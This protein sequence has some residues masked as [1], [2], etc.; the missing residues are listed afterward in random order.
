M[1]PWGSAAR[2]KLG[3]ELDQKKIWRNSRKG[4]LC[5]KNWAANFSVQVL[6]EF[7]GRRPTDRRR[8]LD[9]PMFGRCSV[10]VRSMLGR[11][12]VDAQSMFGRCSFDLG[13]SWPHVWATATSRTQLGRHSVDARSM[14]GQHSVDARSML[15]RPSVDAPSLKAQRRKP[16]YLW[17]KDFA[18]QVQSRLEPS[19]TKI[20]TE[21]LVDQF[22]THD[23]AK[24]WRSS[25]PDFPTQHPLTETWTKKYEKIGSP[26]FWAQPSFTGTV[27]KFWSSWTAVF[28][29]QLSLTE[30]WT[31]KCEKIGSPVFWAQPSFTGTV[32]N[33]L[34]Q[35]NRSFLHA[36]L[37]HPNLDEKI[38]KNWQPSFLSTTFL[39][40]N[41]CKI[42]GPV[43][44]RF[45]H[46]ALPHRNLDGKIGS[47]VS[48]A[49]FSHQ[50]LA[51]KI[52]GPTQ[53]Q[54]FLARHSPTESW[55]ENLVQ[56]DVLERVRM[57][58]R[59]LVETLYTR[60][61]QKKTHWRK[62]TAGEKKRGPQWG[63]TGGKFLS[64][65]LALWE[66]NLG[67]VAPGFGP[68]N[69]RRNVWASDLIVVW[70]LTSMVW[71]FTSPA[72]LI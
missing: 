1:I 31:K 38:W 50:G 69:C 4:R 12:S 53:S 72:L 46:A 71:P 27:A 60:K 49:Q 68:N 43:E 16:K 11:C 59:L 13:L 37:P 9:R 22:F 19:L 65:A 40:R 33:F 36:A 5:A 28:F 6:V 32:A 3:T 17:V 58:S 54:V 44:P 34:V 14:L 70:S 23:S 66:R 21:T 45:L 67:W 2:K 63:L 48:W 47:Q 15:G 18:Q 24:K 39:Y 56:P 41:C 20:W 57:D 64:K 10:D 61:T 35:L 29:A 55:T 62:K 8:T 42:F 25:N 26:V 7:G 51:S 30:T 52:F